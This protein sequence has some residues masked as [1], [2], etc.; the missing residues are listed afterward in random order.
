MRTTNPI[1]CRVREVAVR[2]MPV[3]LFVRMYARLNRRAGTDVRRV[4]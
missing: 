4:A 3:S 1:A 2:L